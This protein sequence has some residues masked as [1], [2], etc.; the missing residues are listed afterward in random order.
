VAQAGQSDQPVAIAQGLEAM[1]GGA[2][3]RGRE[4][5]EAVKEIPQGLW[6]IT[7]ATHDQR[8]AGIA[9]KA[10][11]PRIGSKYALDR[12]SVEVIHMA[13]VLERVVWLVLMRSG[14]DRRRDQHGPTGDTSHLGKHHLGVED[15]LDHLSRIHQIEAAIG[16]RQFR[17]VRGGSRHA[18]AGVQLLDRDVRDVHPPYIGAEAVVQ[19]PH[20]EAFGAADVERCLKRHVL[21]RAHKSDTPDVMPE[22]TGRICLA[23]RMMTPPTRQLVIHVLANTR[24]KLT[25]RKRAAIRRHAPILPSEVVASEPLTGHMRTIGVRASELERTIEAERAPGTDAH[26]VKRVLLIEEGGIGGVANYTDE[27]ACA[28]CAQGVQ[29]LL[30]T[31]TDHARDRPRGVDI[32]PIFPYIRGRGPLGRTVRRL[33]LSKPV[34][35]LAHLAATLAAAR[36]ARRCDLVHVQGEEWPP[37]GAAQALILRACGRRIVY[38]P[39]NTFDRGTRSYARANALIRRCAA[40]IVVHSNYDRSAMSAAQAAKTVVIPHGEYGGL[41]RSGAPDVDAASARAE[42]GAGDEE[43]VVLLFGQ[44]RPDKGVRDLL[45]AGADVPRVRIVLA[46]EDN[47]ALGEVADLLADERLRGRA[48]VQPGYAS[49]AQAARLFAACDVVALPYRRASASG[50][51]LLAYGYA[52]PVL[53][54][55]VGGLPEYV[56]DG[57]TGW[58]CEAAEPAA[59]VHGL[60]AVLAAGRAECSARGEAAERFSEERFAWDTIAHRT[61]GLYEEALES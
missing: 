61:I 20:E 48:I 37:L 46:G 19:S 42:L 28:L 30:A 35:G 9:T 14:A 3:V 7:P 56:E 58:I 49:A 12:R 4:V 29:V 27:L 16:K 32:H 21:Q 10:V 25:T 47:G 57:R 31:G 33:R 11:E 2:D 18:G 53:I 44:L 36:L 24:G 38:T 41:A 13:L 26:R 8:Q 55:P 43:L 51:L 15:V 34:N 5:I 22:C 45:L 6:Q 40:R 54:Y 60:Q 52:R 59:L 23:R 39:H 50:V 17:R 1:L